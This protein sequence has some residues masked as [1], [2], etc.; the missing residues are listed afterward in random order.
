MSV[1]FVTASVAALAG[2][3]LSAYDGLPPTLRLINGSAP[4]NF[5]IAELLVATSRDARTTIRLEPGTAVDGTMAALDAVVSGAAELAVVENSAE[6]R[7]QELRTVVPLYPSVLHVAVR[8]TR[9]ATTFAELL[10]GARVLAGAED[11]ASRMLLS[12]LDSLYAASGI[13]FTYV[14][15]LADDPDVVL[16]FAPISPGRSPLLEGY[17]LF[18]MGEPAALGS[19]TMAEALTP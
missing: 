1:R 9:P 18:S 7:H 6:F 16:V 10:D 11:S 15:T 3:G 19:G 17:R 8:E 4:A 2:F 12:R 13:A 5:E 14:E